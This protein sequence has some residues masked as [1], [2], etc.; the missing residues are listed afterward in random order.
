M[1]CHRRGPTWGHMLGVSATG[2]F[3]SL[4]LDTPKCFTWVMGRLGDRIRQARRHARIS[5]F[6]LARRV[7][8]ARSAVAQWEQDNGTH[9][10]PVNL[11]KVAIATAV[12]FEWLATG[13]GRM[14][15]S[16]DLHGAGDA[17]VAITFAAQCEV[18]ARALVGLRRLD[19]S[20]MLAIVGM[21]EAL[22]AAKR[23]GKAPPLPYSR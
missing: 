9:P 11:A 12:K 20:S 14:G 6:A 4:T 2:Q 1:A 13:R 10:L 3:V 7:G 23:A 22:G 18:E 8:V 17:A 15:F 21:I 16:S 5:Q 19:Y